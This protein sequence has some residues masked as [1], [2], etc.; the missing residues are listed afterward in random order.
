MMLQDSISAIGGI[1]ILLLG[2]VLM[3]EAIQ[4]LAGPRFRKIL[5]NLTGGKLK[6][7]FTGIFVT[8]IIQASSATAIATIGF[9]S[10]GLITIHQALAVIFGANVGTTATA[11]LVTFFGIQYSIGQF[12]LL[13]VACGV[14]LKILYTDH[15]SDIGS[16]LAGFG[17]LFFGITIMRQGLAQLPSTIN[18]SIIAGQSFADMLI[19][20]IIGFTLTILMQSSSAAVVLALVALHSQTIT[21]FQAQTLVIGMNAGKSVPILVAAI[22]ATPDTKRI[23]VADVIFNSATA[24]LLFIMLPQLSPVLSSLFHYMGAIAPEIQLSVFHTLFNVIGVFLFT[25]AITPL[26]RFLKTLFA[27]TTLHLT[28]HLD[29]AIAKTPAIAVETAR[30]SVVE[31]ALYI[32]AILKDLLHKNGSDLPRRLKTAMVALEETKHFMSKVKTP[33]QQKQL[34]DEHISV[35]HAIDHLSSIIEACQEADTIALLKDS[36][37]F[38]DMKWNFNNELNESE[39]ALRSQSSIDSVEKIQELSQYLANARKLERVEVLR[40][41]ASGILDSHT[42]L[43]YIEAIR[44]IDRL[45]YHIW[46][47]VR[48]CIAPGDSNF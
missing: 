20:F 21:L 46:R 32:I 29:D 48:H 9:V 1:G 5:S 37:N 35:L 34:Y 18:F 42:A 3:S 39:K 26:V 19:L 24:L 25:P 30:R 27:D 11:W 15:R 17:L 2:I 45:G 13:F 10:A 31:I 38:V 40:K 28:Q 12:S 8:T 7:L 6:A 22:G 41:T 14:I 16:L 36:N 4:K 23:I 47:V 44:F 43:D 33:P